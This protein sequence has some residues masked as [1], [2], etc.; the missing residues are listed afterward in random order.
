MNLEHY[1]PGTLI[2]ISSFAVADMG[3]SI[4]LYNIGTGKPDWIEYPQCITLLNFTHNIELLANDLDQASFWRNRN[5]T[6]YF[7]LINEKEYFIEKEYLD[8][9]IELMQNSLEHDVKIIL[10][11]S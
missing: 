10:P 3:L 5:L 2:L 1:E 7:S 11:N 4:T 8:Y 6:G 9:I